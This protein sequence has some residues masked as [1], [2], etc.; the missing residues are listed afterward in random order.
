MKYPVHESET[1]SFQELARAS[2]V[3]FGQLSILEIEP[4]CSRGGHYHERK[5]EWFCCVKGVCRLDMRPGLSFTL[6]GSDRKLVHVPSGMPHTL[7]N[8]GQV[9]FDSTCTVLVISSE[10]YAPDDPDTYPVKGAA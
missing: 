4:G 2:D 3:K 1:G 9:D 5:E 6:F 10:E 8:V 7:I